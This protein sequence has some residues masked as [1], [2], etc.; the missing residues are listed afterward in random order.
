MLR[1]LEKF[2]PQEL[3][4]RHLPSTVIT[5]L[6]IGFVVIL[7]RGLGLAREVF[8]AARLGTTTEA[9]IVVTLLSVPDSITSIILAG[10]L[11]V[12]VVP[13][14]QQYS[15]A[16]RLT[17]Y[18]RLT[19]RVLCYFLPFLI[20]FI[21]TPEY[22]LKFFALGVVWSELSLSKVG[23]IFTSISI[24][25][26]AS[27][28]I[29]SSALN[30]LGQYKFAA[31][32]TVIF[33]SILIA[34]LVALEDYSNLFTVTSFLLFAACFLRFLAQH[35]R[36]KSYLKTD[37]YKSGVHRKTTRFEFRGAFFSGSVAAA[38]TII[39]PLITRSIASLNGS[40]YLSNFNYSQKLVEFP[41]GVLIAPLATVCY[42]TLCRI[43]TEKPSDVEEYYKYLR[44]SLR[45][46]WVI[47]TSV[48]GA[49]APL[50]LHLIPEGAELVFKNSIDIEY[51]SSS[52]L[53]G[54]GTVPLIG[55]CQILMADL[56]A[57]GKRKKLIKS[58]VLSFIA[59]LFFIGLFTGTN[60]VLNPMLYMFLYYLSLS[61]MLIFKIINFSR[62]DCLRLTLYLALVVGLS[63]SSYQFY[64]YQKLEYF[65]NNFLFLAL[66]KTS[67]AIGVLIIILLI[68]LVL[69]SRHSG[70]QS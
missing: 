69:H 61:S 36:F 60:V 18:L 16:E 2:K 20:L 35:L 29:T 22:F 59:F 62:H 56:N 4:A 63:F 39:V 47:T 28:L 55:H 31:F 50:L 21:F 54:L 11:S 70:G 24:L 38:I 52:V 33:N 57:R 9:D 53:I 15:S 3:I 13:A 34:G 51:F 32:G 23:V 30:G 40:G 19:R 67:M 8:I 66:L 41:L 10:G 42:T 43:K 27:T 5:G 25:L 46:M 44:S 64:N 48:I 6:L 1:L 49:G 37:T 7:G 12:A 26:S 58:N 14:L 17:F 65:G 68:N 45:S